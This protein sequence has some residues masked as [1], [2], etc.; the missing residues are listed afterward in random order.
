MVKVKKKDESLLFLCFITILRFN[1]QELVMQQWLFDK[2]FNQNQKLGVG[3]LE[4]PLLILAGA[5]SGKTRV[6]TYRIV[7]LILQRK[8]Q[9]ERVLAVTFTNKAANEMK[10][11]CLSL[12]EKQGVHDIAPPWIGTFHA[13]GAYI[14]RRHIDLLGYK[15]SFNI[16]D[17]AEQLQ[18]VKRIMSH[19]NMNEQLYP[20]KRLQ[21]Q[22]NKAKR[23]A[24]PPDQVS[25]K[26]SYDVQTIA[27]YK[28]YEEEMKQSSVLDFSDLLLKTYILFKKDEDILDSYR[29]F[30]QFIHVD[31]YQDTNHIQYLI[32]KMLAK[33]HRNICVVGDE[34]Q[35]IYG[36]R[37]AD[38]HNILSFEKDYPEAKIIK[39]EENYRSTQ[40]II[41]AASHLI[42]YNTERK[43]K[44][45]FS[46]GHVG[47]KIIIQQEN[48][49]RAEASRVIYEIKQLMS[50]KEA[51]FSDFAIF[52]RTHAQSRILEEKFL[53]ENIPH[54]LV[55]GT[56]FYERREIKDLLFYLRFLLNPAE[57]IAFL[58]IINTPARGIGKTTISKIETIAIQNQTS[59]VKASAFAI[60]QNLLPT[61]TL[62]KLSDFLTLMNYLKGESQNLSVSDIYK[63]ILEKTHYIQRLKETEE[64]SEVQMRID[65]LKELHNAIEHF[66]EEK[67]E[68]AT[69]QAFL[70]R[71]A[72]INETEESQQLQDYVTLM[73]LHVSKGLEFPY[74]FIVGMEEGLFPTASALES[75]NSSN[76]LEEE[77]RLA[78]VGMTRAKE[79]L[80]LTYARE[81]RTASYKK[82]YPIPSRFLTEIPT[83]YIIGTHR[84]SLFMKRASHYGFS[85][86]AVGDVQAY[87]KPNNYHH[88]DHFDKMPDYES[89][90]NENKSIGKGSR[91]R[92]SRFGVGTV[93]QTE[94]RDES[95]KVTV[96]FDDN[97]I[98]K[99]I[100]KHAGFELL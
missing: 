47:D 93:Y 62:K 89:P 96:L 72:L 52:Y 90:V 39:L 24:L 38:I 95:Q 94:G 4:G 92:H 25:Q 20:P 37:G 98:R 18:T 50:Q 48:N 45:I 65:N 54:R 87:K 44:K 1:N 59:L 67:K 73:T 55:G 42:S 64:K 71:T 31:E 6:L 30:F 88:A 16:C 15:T 84:P 100:T 68:E 77:R 28:A 33:N 46:N 2:D 97:S 79:K 19:L 8:T 40:T 80:Y 9:P 58:R 82:S 86:N 26:L 32:L 22:I 34:D 36:W 13:L 85:S 35:S 49:E 5:G 74:V 21:S 41:N 43:D 75:F 70:E 53:S 69:L 12:L 51:K 63:L 76:S 57:N 17:S 61:G 56:K 81:R 60:S 10:S 78:Y 7:N 83:E 66:E 99:F 11:R 23:L 14:L 29:N 91:V 3:H 27:F